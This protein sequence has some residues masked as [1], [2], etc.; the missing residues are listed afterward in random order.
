MKIGYYALFLICIY[1]YGTR[2]ERGKVLAALYVMAN[3]RGGYSN[4]LEQVIS[5]FPDTPY[6]DIDD[7]KLALEK[8]EEYKRNIRP[9]II[10]LLQIQLETG[11]YQI[12]TEA[13]LYQCLTK[14]IH[15]SRKDHTIGDLINTLSEAKYNTLTSPHCE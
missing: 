15:P 9:N 5:S 2:E 7:I 12:D 8:D 14:K 13:E 4:T 11:M 10:H 3:A 1:N 6:S